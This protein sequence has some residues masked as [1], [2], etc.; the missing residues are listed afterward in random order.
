[1]VEEKFPI[2]GAK[3][4]G[5]HIRQSQ[6]GFCSFLLM[7]LSKTLLQF[8]VIIPSQK[9]ITHSCWTV[10]SEVYFSPAEKGRGG[11]WSWKKYQN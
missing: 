11:L 8:F 7:P 1:M 4:T 2:Y 9:E 6:N 3:I 5:K 10:F